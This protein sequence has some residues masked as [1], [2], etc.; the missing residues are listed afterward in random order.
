MIVEILSKS[1]AD[2][3]ALLDSPE[4]RAAVADVPNFATGGATF[5]FDEETVIVPFEVVENHSPEA[6]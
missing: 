5:L 3:E 6:D 2:L 4:G 1:R